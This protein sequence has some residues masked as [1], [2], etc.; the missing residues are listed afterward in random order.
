[1]KLFLVYIQRLKIFFFFK[2]VN[3]V[4]DARNVFESTVVF[5]ELSIDI[6][7][8]MLELVAGE[9]STFCYLKV[10]GQKGVD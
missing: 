10:D 4:S 1:L 9:L 8:D 5:V 6:N 2:L 3:S 7:R